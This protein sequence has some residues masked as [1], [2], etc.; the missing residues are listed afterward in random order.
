MQ[1][2]PSVVGAAGPDT[3]FEV[4][5]GSVAAYAAAV[6]AVVSDVTPP[7]YAALPLQEAVSPLLKSLAA[8]KARTRVV[9]LAHELVADRPLAAGDRVV[10][11]AT[12]TGLLPRSSGTAAV[13]RTSTCTHSGEPVNEQRVTLFFRG[14]EID[15]AVGEAPTRNESAAATET[16]ATVVPIAADLPDRYA[17]ASGDDFAIHLDDAFARSVGLKGRIVHGMCTLAIAVRIIIG[18]GAARRIAAEFAAPLYPGSDL[19]VVSWPGGFAAFSGGE[20][21]LGR[22]LLER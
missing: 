8:P 3:V 2:D 4:T 6:G 18:D 12:V 20:T 5:A 7:L 9:H 17:A 15:E 22:G 21:V 19:T 1:L 11:S 10:T 13:I 14:V 16:T